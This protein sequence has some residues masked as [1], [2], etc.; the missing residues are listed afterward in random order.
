M[1]VAVH[2]NWALP[3]L[4]Y[5]ITTLTDRLSD[6][7]IDPRIVMAEQSSQDVV[8]QEQSVDGPS[9]ADVSATQTTHS[10]ARAAPEVA[11]K[12]QIHTHPTPSSPNTT[13]QSHSNDGSPI[14][15]DGNVVPKE[16]EATVGQIN[17]ILDR[18]NMCRPLPV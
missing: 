14:A 1:P 11:T 2:P 4:Y 8:I 12:V 17:A 5:E 16:L 3:V 15:T 7:G 18:T 13:E 9:S 10:T 6:G